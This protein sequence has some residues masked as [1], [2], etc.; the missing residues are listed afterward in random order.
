[1]VD[2]MKVRCVRCQETDRDAEEY[3]SDHEEQQHHGRD[4]AVVLLEPSRHAL[5]GRQLGVFVVGSSVSRGLGSFGGDVRLVGVAQL[6]RGRERYLMAHWLQPSTSRGRAG[7]RGLC[8]CHNH[9]ARSGTHLLMS[10]H[11]VCSVGLVLCGTSCHLTTRTMMAATS[12]GLA[13]RHR[14]DGHQ[15][16]QRTRW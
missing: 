7:G 8:Y 14:P 12:A 13:Q 10:R 3:Q 15:S 6:R 2:S 5:G 16:H 9:D 4:A 11:V 1:M